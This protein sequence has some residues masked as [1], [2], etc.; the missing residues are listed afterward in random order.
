MTK[1]NVKKTT[2]TPRKIALIAAMVIMVPLAFAFLTKPTSNLF[3]ISKNLS[4]F[5]SVYKEVDLY[6]VDE[7][8]PG[9]FMKTGIDAMLESLDPYTNYI[10]ESRI[11]DYRLMT[12][13]E[14][15][16]IGALIRKNEDYIIISE[17]YDGFPAQKAGLKAGDIILEV[18]GKDA[19]AKTTS[20][21]STL[22]KG[23]SGTEL[24]VKIDRAGEIFEKNLIREKVKIADVPYSGMIDTEVGYVKL[25]SFT[26]TASEN[27]G[28][29]IK[30]LKEKGMQQ[31]I[32]DLRGNGGGLLREAVNI[33]NFFVPKGTKVVETKGRV[34]E[35]NHIYKTQNHP[36][37]TEM[38]LVVLVDE[39]SASAS[40]IVAGSIQDLDRG[41]VIG[42]NSFGKGLVQQT[43]QLEYNAQVKITIAKYYT[44]SGRCIQRLDYSDHDNNGKGK[45]VADSLITVFK[46]KNG[47]DVKDG[48]G[49]DPD[50]EVDP[51]T[52]SVLSATVMAN[53]YI[54]D[55][56]TAYQRSH[57]TIPD[58]KTFTISD[59]EYD[60]FTAFVLDKDFEYTNASLSYLDKLEK[61][62]K[63]EK[64]FEDSKT[65]FA[66]LK[67]SLKTDKAEDMKRFKEEMIELL[68]N[69]IASRYYYQN[70]RV[71]VALKRDPYI[72]STIEVLKDQVRYKGILEGTVK[73]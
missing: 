52:Y 49:I 9:A 68:E 24:K 58:A 45:T 3:E 66:A 6:Y 44:P 65:E 17:P 38:P 20:E 36:I 72:A 71:E 2:I 73:E 62:A 70:G 1:I 26:Q 25:T 16:G 69:E 10:P 46:T 32:L 7:V 42:M 23:Q 39:N 31:L 55:Y 61:V 21:I 53:N 67:E 41:V 50:I 27:V 43:K 40:E 30:E 15:G 19:K 14:Y 56:A 13:G 54:F 48:R 34:A 29:A 60:E 64:Y 51:G 11:E 4:I 5:S 35:V 57:E 47:R 12:T 33:V 28:K 37:D 18:D 63:T 22:L 59:A 8:E